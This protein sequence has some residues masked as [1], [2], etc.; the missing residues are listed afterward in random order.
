MARR[1]TDPII[2]L[3]L[4]TVLTVSGCGVLPGGLVSTRDFNVTDFI[5]MPISMIYTNDSNV[6]FRF[7]DISTSKEQAISF[8]ERVVKH[9]VSLKLSVFEISRPI[10]DR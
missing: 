10:Q 6:A 4:V 2:S 1:W 7:P 5:T 9:A 8:V 3:L